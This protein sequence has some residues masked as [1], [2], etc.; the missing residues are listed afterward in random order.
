MRHVRWGKTTR[1][2]ILK[3]FANNMNNDQQ[4]KVT[5]DFGYIM[6]QQSPQDKKTGL[7]KR[8]VIIIACIALMFILLLLSVLLPSSKSKPTSTTGPA[9]QKVIELKQA[10]LAKDYQTAANIMAGDRSDTERQNLVAELQ[11]GS[12]ADINS[13][14]VTHV[15]VKG[16]V[17]YVD[18]TCMTK[19]KKIKFTYTYTVLNSNGTYSI[20]GGEYKS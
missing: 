2:N 5:P 16:N 6:N 4:P 15:E 11:K 13:C 10:L 9:A 19:D 7:D 17:S 20:I 12:F 3:V 14:Q 8:I 1:N 18:H